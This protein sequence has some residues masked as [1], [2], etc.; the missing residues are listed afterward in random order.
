M[1]PHTLCGHY[2]KDNSNL[3]DHNLTALMEGL[4]SAVR[5]FIWRFLPK[6]RPAL[7]GLRGLIG[8]DQLHMNFCSCR[9]IAKGKNDS[10]ICLVVSAYYHFHLC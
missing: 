3:M 7:S 2:Y 10:T 6:V 1:K 8:F 9:S 5:Q 4:D